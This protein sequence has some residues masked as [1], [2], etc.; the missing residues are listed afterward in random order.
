VN[1]AAHSLTV[2]FAGTST[3][4]TNSPKSL[5]CAVI[6][7]YVGFLDVANCSVIK[8]WA[9]DA[10]NLNQS[11][12]VDIWNGSSL[13]TTVSANQYRPDIATYLHD[14]GDHGFNFSTPATLQDGGSHTLT[15][16][17]AGTT[18]ALTNTQTVSGCLPPSFSISGVST[19]VQLQQGLT[20]GP[21]QVSVTPQYGFTGTVTMTVSGQPSGV[22]ITSPSQNIS[23]TGTVYLSSNVTA[24]SNAQVGGPYSL[25]ATVSGNGVTK[26]ISLSLTITAA[27]PPTLLITCNILPNPVNLG[28]SATLKAYASGGI[29]PYQ[30]TL[31]GVS[32]GG[33]NSTILS[34]TSVGTIG[35]PV[36]VR[37]SQPQTASS[38]CSV[39]VNGVA[40]TAS[41]PSWDTQ[42]RNHT[43][44]SGY[45]YGSGFVSSTTVWFCVNGTTTCY[46]Q[47]T[48]LVT[49]QS[50]YTIRVTNA[51]ITTGT[52]QIEVRTP[53]GTARSP[54][55]SVTP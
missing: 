3:A 7:Q 45:V 12:S 55:F 43:Y 52:W 25:T 17:V 9:A 13:L 48:P 1:G 30:Y 41:T 14:N 27:P 37:D 39:T 28:L 32:T 8:G 4:L 51:Y 53:Y 22:T 35:Y 42:P 21:F 46:Q 2:K 24:A 33:S 5:T 11:L 31:N 16:K 15:A 26:T 36:S 10:N 44:F 18:S 49:V 47:P 50:L 29:P 40:P 34:P 38:A 54:A 23:G 20:G 6:H 19:N